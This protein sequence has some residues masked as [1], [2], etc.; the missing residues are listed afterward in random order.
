[1]ACS[2]AAGGLSG[3]LAG[4]DLGC[5]GVGGLED[6]LAQQLLTAGEQVLDVPPKLA[7][8]MRLLATGDTNKNDPQR[9]PLGCGRGA[10]LGRDPGGPA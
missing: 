3:G 2:P 4:A 8:R 1:M 10:A 5:R 6:L 7:A 9:C